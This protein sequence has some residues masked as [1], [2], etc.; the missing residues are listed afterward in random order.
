MKGLMLRTCRAVLRLPVVTR[1]SVRLCSGAGGGRVGPDRVLPANSLT[2]T[3]P[4]GAVMIRDQHPHESA[5][6]PPKS[7]WTMLQVRPG[8]KYT[9]CPVKLFLLCYLLFC[10]LLL[11]QITKVG[12][13]F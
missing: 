2:T 13:F 6:Y 4:D 8:S 5:T 9:G 3:W 1:G 7:V 12:T 11:V 10:W